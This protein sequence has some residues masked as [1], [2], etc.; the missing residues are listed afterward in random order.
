MTD[1]TLDA[2][3]A[4]FQ[5]SSLGLFARVYAPMR[6]L[7]VILWSIDFSWSA[8]VWLLSEAQDFWGKLLRKLLVFFLLW[9]LLTLAPYWLW[10][11]LD[12]FGFLA[13]ELTAV[14]GLSPSG[15]LDQ[16]VHLFFSMFSSWEQIASLFHPVGVFLRLFTAVTLLAA[17]TLIAAALV[18]VLV[19]GALAL[20]GLPFF[21]GFAGHSLTW[22]LAEGYFKYLLHLGVRVFVIY[23]LV[24]IGNNLASIW[25]TALQ[26]ASA[27]SLFTDPRLFVAIPVTAAIWA[28]LVL[29]VPGAIAREITGPFSMSGL[30]PMGR[31]NR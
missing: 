30:N 14:D 27:F 11:V 9:G 19:E 23:L 3:V 16:G 28:G 18:R 17:F 24:G 15:V 5:G 26:E 7:F 2:I 13:G 8:G 21:L 20:G 4:L 6:T 31:A 12:G 29:V 1:G 10:R 25:D 22:G